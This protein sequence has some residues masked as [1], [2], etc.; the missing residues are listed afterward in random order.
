[1]GKIKVVGLGPG[2]IEQLPF[3]VYQLLKKEQPL[4]LRTK[5]HPVVKDLE[6]EGLVFQSFDAIY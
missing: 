6:Q 5:L 2:D 3:G 1:M 4:Y